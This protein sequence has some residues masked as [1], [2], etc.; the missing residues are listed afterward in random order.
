MKIYIR[1]LTA[2]IFSAT[3]FNLRVYAD[4]ATT[5]PTPTTTPTTTTASTTPSTYNASDGA[6]KSN[7]SAGQIAQ[8]VGQGLLSAGTGM[9]PGCV[10]SKC[11]CCPAAAMLIAMG[12]LG[13]IQAGGNKGSSG[14]NAGVAGTAAGYG[15]TNP[16]GDNYDTSG[17]LDSNGATTNPAV[18]AATKEAAK[19]GVKY[20]ATTG[21]VTTPDGKSMKLSDVMNKD[22][23]ANSG[24]SAGDYANA[25]A[26]AANLEKLGAAKA[27]AESE[28]IGAHTAAMGFAEG[29]G[30]GGGNRAGSADSSDASGAGSGARTPADAKVSVA[31]MRKG[32]NGDMIGV[33]GDSI[34]SMM[35]RRYQQKSKEEGFLF[36]ESKPE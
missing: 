6:S 15:T 22:A 30:S 4:E 20:N 31:G 32:Y 17:N 27:A 29:G 23:M 18:L 16:Y 5:T 8:T 2:F 35:N 10:A 11:S 14:Q 13:L 21:T 12:I 26:Q 19:A 3:S 28:K 34:F 24:V 9:M 1:L 25:M 36:P 7:G 33:S